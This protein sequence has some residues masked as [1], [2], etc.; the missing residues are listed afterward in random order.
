MFCNNKLRNAIIIFFNEVKK[1]AVVVVL[2]DIIPLYQSQQYIQC[3]CQCRGV[4]KC[5]DVPH[6]PS[7]P[8]R[9]VGGA[10]FWWASLVV[11]LVC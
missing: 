3:H 8:G 9:H 2:G 11:S 1:A 4:K 6:K 7:C 5:F 10:L